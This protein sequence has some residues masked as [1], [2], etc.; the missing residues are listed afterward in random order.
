MQP[1]PLPFNPFLMQITTWNIRGYNSALKKRLLKR[2]IDK[3]K[4]GIIFLQETKCSGE[5]LASIDQKVW[6]GCESIAIDTRGAV[7]GLG[8]L[9]N[10]RVVSLLGFLTTNCTISADFHILD[11]RIRGSISNFYGPLKVDQKP[12]FLKSLSGLKNLVQDKAWIMGG[13]FKLIRNL[14]KKGGIR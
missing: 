9:W 8:I 4:L 2:R 14:H 3:E 11:G 6:K 5:Y 10:P 7:G 12:A 13:D 1:F